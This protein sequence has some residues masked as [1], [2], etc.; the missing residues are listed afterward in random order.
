MSPV[1]HFSKYSLHRNSEPNKQEATLIVV[2]MLG[3]AGP[4]GLDNVGVGLPVSLLSPTTMASIEMRVHVL[5]EP[6]VRVTGVTADVTNICAGRRPHCKT[7]QARQQMQKINHAHQERKT[8]RG[9]TSCQDQGRNA[10]HLIQRDA[11]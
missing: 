4:G 9:R 6:L 10:R 1:L 11:L 2:G 7:T 3:N 8:L 5:T